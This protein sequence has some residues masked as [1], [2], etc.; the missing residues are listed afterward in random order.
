M[1]QGANEALAP[2]KSI[3]VGV[4]DEEKLILVLPENFPYVT[5]DQDDLQRGKEIYKLFATTRPADFSFLAQE[6]VRA[7]D[8]GRTVSHLEALL[9]MAANGSGTRETQVQ[10]LPT[11][12]EWT[13]IEVAFYVEK[14]GI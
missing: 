8:V 14:R 6:G 2:G 12:A 5:G 1:A 4:S 9:S 11:D 7:V 3:E 10:R 13:T